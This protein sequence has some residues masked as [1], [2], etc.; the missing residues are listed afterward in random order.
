MK[1]MLGT[2]TGTMTPVFDPA[3]IPMPPAVERVTLSLTISSKDGVTYTVAGIRAIVNFGSG[4]PGA[5]HEAPWKG[6]FTRI[7]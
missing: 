7:E 4:I 1:P 2:S 6:T 5:G 3:S